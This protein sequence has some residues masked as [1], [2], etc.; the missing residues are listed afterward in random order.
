MGNFKSLAQYMMQ[1]AVISTVGCQAAEFEDAMGF[2]IS[3]ELDYLDAD[4]EISTVEEVLNEP[5]ATVTYANGRM[6][7]EPLA[8]TAWYNTSAAVHASSVVEGNFAATAEVAVMN[9]RGGVVAPQWRIGGL[10][11]RSLD[12]GPI[13]SYL[14]GFGTPDRRTSQ[15]PVFEFK[16]TVSS[17]STIGS[18]SHPSGR[19]QIRLC[20]FGSTVRALY[21]STSDD[22]WTVADTRER[23]E[24]DGPLAVGPVAYNYHAIPDL[25]AEFESLDFTT[26]DSEDE[27]ESAPFPAEAFEEEPLDE[28]EP[29]EG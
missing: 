25:R 2:R 27:C 5:A 14:G 12:D 20:R 11:M 8:Y 13:Q 19:G 29:I 1:V 7:I 22:P 17:S 26:L 28:V 23:P 9:R 24:L 4:F 10:L 18:S 21:R 3:S 6:I 15:V 16:S